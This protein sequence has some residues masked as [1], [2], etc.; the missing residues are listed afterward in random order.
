[1]LVIV[2]V[3]VVVCPRVMPVAGE[4]DSESAMLGSSTV[5]AVVALLAAEAAKVLVSTVP[6]TEFAPLVAVCPWTVSVMVQPP[7]LVQVTTPKSQVVV[8]PEV[9][10]VGAVQAAPLQRMVPVTTGAVALW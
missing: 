7:T 10:V 3:T 5:T 6:R 9:A 8:W 2:A 4:A 1:M